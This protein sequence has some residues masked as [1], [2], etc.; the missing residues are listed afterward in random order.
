MAYLPSDVASIFKI[1]SMKKFYLLSILLSSTSVFTQVLNDNETIPINQSLE[2]SII[3]SF[4]APSSS[5]TDITFDGEFLWV[6]SGNNNATIYKISP[7]NGSVLQEIVTNFISVDGVTFGD[8]YLFAAE[9]GNGSNMERTVLKIDP[10]TGET[11][12]SFYISYGNYTHGMEYVGGNLYVNVLYLNDTDITY[13]LNT[14]G[15]IIEQF[16]NNLNFS[17]GI[18]WDGCNFWISSNLP[19]ASTPRLNRIN[20]STFEILD[21]DVAPGGGYPN[22]VAWDGNYIWVTNNS[23]DYI[24]QID[25]STC[26]L[27]VEKSK[28]ED[29]DFYPNPVADYLNIEKGNVSLTEIRIIDLHGKLLMNEFENFNRLNLIHLS[30][31]IY[32][33]QFIN[34]QKSLT[35]K[36]IKL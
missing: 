35:K 15:T 34:N 25:I 36:L 31:G 24:Y 29:I 11:I 30:S 20:P 6:G 1:S 3:N 2:Y 16:E 8:G 19:T 14:E 22:G 9:T 32:Y 27:G 13:V 17:H 23:S 4:P 28:M 26:N 5:V 33:I 10:I 12:D 18:A 21:Y 7:L